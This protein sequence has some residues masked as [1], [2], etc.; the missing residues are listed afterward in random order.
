MQVNPMNNEK[1]EVNGRIFTRSTYMDIS[2]LIDK[3][4]G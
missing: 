1:F 4:T 3:E 2:V